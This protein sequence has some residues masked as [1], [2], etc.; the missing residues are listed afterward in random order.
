MTLC[1]T[2]CTATSVSPKP[3]IPKAPS[4]SNALD[5]AESDSILELPRHAIERSQITLPGST[6][7]HLKATII[8]ATNPANAGYQA[9]IEEYWVSPQKWRRVVTALHF[10]QTL[11]VN[12]DAVSEDL[13]GDY[14]PNWL[15]TMVNAI[16]DPGAPLTGVDLSTSDDNPMRGGTKF[17]RRFSEA[18]GIAPVTNDVF[19]SY[20][21]E[22]GLL[23]SVVKP[24]YLAAYQ[25]YQPFSGKLVARR[26]GESIDHD[27]RLEA[28]IDELTELNAVA[29]SLFT[30]QQ[31]NTPLQTVRLTEETARGLATNAPAMQ[32][33]PI[34][35][36]K[37]TGVL[38]IYVSIDRGGQVRET[39]ALNTDDPDMSNA[40]RD[41]L[42]N[43]RFEPVVN[44]KG[45][46][47]QAEAILTFAYQTRIQKRAR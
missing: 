31:A 41:Q 42:L 36:G 20:C 7:F 14:D 17:C 40:A 34:E 18:V 15:R 29:E 19:S 9:S 46:P 35:E 44:D 3:S 27:T 21:F 10:S 28:R 13:D 2:A 5:A 47:V 22:R 8:D 4:T 24:G 25:E 32:W 1:L 23:E 33:P 30:I 37:P 45:V 6:P 39:H 26:I 12:G 11:I 16:V 38:S 43:W